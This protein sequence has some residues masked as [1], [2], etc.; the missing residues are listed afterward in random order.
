MPTR[1]YA[2]VQKLATEGH[3]PVTTQL[4][5]LLGAGLDA[6]EVDKGFEDT[7]PRD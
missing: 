3:R 1:V 4:N 2:K 7:G 5:L 6:L